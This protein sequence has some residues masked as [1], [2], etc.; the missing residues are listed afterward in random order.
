MFF[1]GVLNQT[2]LHGKNFC[3]KDIISDEKMFQTKIFDCMK[4]G[5][6]KQKMKN[7]DTVWSRDKVQRTQY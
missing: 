2:N 6:F 3:Q 7:R 5:S 4:K 1:V